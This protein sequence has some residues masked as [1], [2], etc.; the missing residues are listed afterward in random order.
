MTVTRVAAAGSTPSISVGAT[1]STTAGLPC[2]LEATATAGARVHWTKLSGPGG[3]WFDPANAATTQARFSEAGTYVVRCTAEKDGASATA[4]VTVTVTAA[5][6]TCDLSSGLIR[7]WPLSGADMLIDKA[8]NAA[9]T[10]VTTNSAGEVDC[11]FEE[12]LAGHAFRANGFEAYFNLGNALAETK[13]TSNNNSPP[14]ERYRSVS[15]WVWHDTSD[16][17]EYK[18]AAIFM[19]PYGLGLWYNYNCPDGTANGLLLC[20]QGWG[21]ESETEY[22]TLEVYLSFLRK[23]MGFIGSRMKIRAARGLGYALEEKA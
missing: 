10:S 23:K 6:E 11:S 19:V 20:Q 3:A 12:G 14:T 8:R 13:S 16:T 1:A 7:W 22:N 2:A 17:N 9:R 21:L 4:D 18:N 5:E 15:V